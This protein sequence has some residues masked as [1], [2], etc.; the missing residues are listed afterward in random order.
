V[1]D[2]LE[3]MWRGKCNSLMCLE[4]LRKTEKKTMKPPPNSGYVVSKSERKTFKI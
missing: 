2:E 3:R 4:G 1:N